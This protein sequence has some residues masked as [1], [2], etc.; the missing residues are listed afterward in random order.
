MGIIVSWSSDNQNVA[1][2][3]GTGYFSGVA[4]GTFNAQANATLLDQNADCPAGS[5]TQC[6]YSPYFASAVGL[7][8]KP[9]SLRFL[10]VSVLPDGTF[11][12]YGC[13]GSAFYGIRVDIKYQ[14]LDQQNPAQP[15]LSSNMT[16]H[17]QG[18]NFGGDLYD[19]NIG[20]VTGYPTSSATTAADGTFHDVPFGV[21]FQ[22]SFTATATQ[23]ITMIVGATSYPVRSQNWTVSGPTPGHGTIQNSITSPGTGSDVSASR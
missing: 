18:T 1:T 19:S 2:S 12:A 16:P 7:I 6:P 21:C 20:P 5:H 4:P 10:S 9:T 13:L 14:V 8:Q 23:N 22:N 17:E 3:Q 11:G 15:I